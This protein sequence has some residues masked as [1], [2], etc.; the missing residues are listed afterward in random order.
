MFVGQ[1][2][3]GDDDLSKH[4]CRLLQKMVLSILSLENHSSPFPL[5]FEPLLKGS[6]TCHLLRASHLIKEILSLKTF[7]PV[8]LTPRDLILGYK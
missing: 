8:F 5:A 2:H 3:G 6:K 1:L 4:P 7:F